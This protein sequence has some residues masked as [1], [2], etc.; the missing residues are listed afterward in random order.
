M[1]LMEGGDI[2]L[3]KAKP[4]PEEVKYILYSDYDWD[5]SREKAKRWHCVE[6]FYDSY[7]QLRGV[8]HIFFYVDSPGRIQISID[9]INA[10]ATSWPPHKSL[11]SKD[12]LER[13]QITE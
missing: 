7:S 5:N 4:E 2:I 8:M 11:L 9:D 3:R 12:D 6:G 10:A 13:M 1:K